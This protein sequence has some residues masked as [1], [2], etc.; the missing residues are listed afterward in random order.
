MRAINLIKSI[1][2]NNHVMTKYRD[3]VEIAVFNLFEFLRELDK[4]DFEDD[5]LT[6]M[7]VMIKGRGLVSDQVWSLVQYF[8]ALFQ[9]N[10]ESFGHLFSVIN[11]FLDFGSHKF[12]DDTTAVNVLVQMSLTTIKKE[13]K[14]SFGDASDGAVLLQL[15]FQYLKQNPSLDENFNVIL[16]TVFQKIDSDVK[17]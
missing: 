10:R 2:D 5:L 4:I 16:T 8:P 12:R 15:L 6:L 1:I 7:S 11:E 3:A 9:K 14:N 17:I 13:H